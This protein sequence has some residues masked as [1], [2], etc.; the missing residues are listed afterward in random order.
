MYAK[1][2]GLVPTD[3]LN[4]AL[5]ESITLATQNT[6]DINQRLINSINVTKDPAAIQTDINDL[7]T[8]I[9]EI[10]EWLRLGLPLRTEQGRGL[11]SMQ[12]PTQGVPY[13]EFAKMTAAEKYKLNKTGANYEHIKN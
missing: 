4:Y 2:Y 10:D 13:E 1:M 12:I 5:A 11:R 6:A 8:S 9:G 7:V 3:E